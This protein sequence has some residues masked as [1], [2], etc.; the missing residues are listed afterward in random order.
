MTKLLGSNP[1]C[2]AST[3]EAHVNGKKQRHLAISCSINYTGNGLPVFLLTKSNAE[4]NIVVNT[5]TSDTSRIPLIKTSSIKTRLY[6]NDSGV[7]FQC[8]ITFH[9]PNNSERVDVYMYTWNYTP[10]C[11]QSDNYAKWSLL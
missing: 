9:F 8:K 7:T 11:K 1:L 10:P 5:T 4:K 3:T 6:L 2:D